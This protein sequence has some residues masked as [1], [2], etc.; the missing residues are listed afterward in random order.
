MLISRRSLLI[1]LAVMAMA[2]LSPLEEMAHALASAHMVQHLLLIL[3]A[4]PLLSKAIR[5]TLPKWVSPPLAWLLHTATIWFWHA[6]GPYNAAVV[7]PLLHGL[8]HLS[9]LGTA[10]VFWRVV[11]IGRQPEGIGVLLVFAMALQSVFL[12]LLL[13]FADTPWYWVYSAT[14]RAYGL[15]PLADQ[16][17]AGVIMWV[18]AGLVYTG[19]GLKLLLTWI[20]QHDP[21]PELSSS[22]TL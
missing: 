8:E 5:F 3:V 17:L 6:A 4:A 19:I 11:G 13:T 9:F 20:R 10:V 1:A 18:P 7:N 21:A 12:A 16:Q 15:D 2:L 14:T 22:P